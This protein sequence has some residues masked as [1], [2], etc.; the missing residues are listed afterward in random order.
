MVC[1][2]NKHAEAQHT[3]TPDFA[4]HSVRRIHMPCHPELLA[5]FYYDQ[6][7]HDQLYGYMC[8]YIYIYIYIYTCI[9]NTHVYI[10]IY[11]YTHTYIHIHICVYIYMIPSKQKHEQGT[12]RRAIRSATDSTRCFRSGENEPSPLSQSPALRFADG[13]GPGGGKQMYPLL[14]GVFGLR[15]FGRLEF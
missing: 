6:L 4:T 5:R 7:N 11:I 2:H 3:T 9:Y 14:F 15:A 1:K 10:Y 13:E 8:V 12:A